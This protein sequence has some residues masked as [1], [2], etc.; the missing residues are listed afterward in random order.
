[1]SEYKICFWACLKKD[2]IRSDRNKVAFLIIFIY[3]LGNTIYY[4]N[5]KLKRVIM[6]LLKIIQFILVRIP[7][8]VDIPFE[9]KIGEGL[10]L[11]HPNGCFINKTAIIGKNCTIYQQV[12]IGASSG[13]EVKSPIIKNNVYFGAG[14]KAI[15]E[16]IIEDNVKIGANAV[17]VK[18][19][20]ENSTVIC[21]QEILE[22]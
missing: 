13:K 15:G 8:G 3:R 9:T 18:S 22:R 17:V 7:F 16:I 5:I 19:V 4:S 14:A 10:R 21:R 2:Y 12:T 11:V 20:K 6:L 1:M